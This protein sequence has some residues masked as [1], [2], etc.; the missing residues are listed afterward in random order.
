MFDHPEYHGRQP[1]PV[2]SKLSHAVRPKSVIL[3]RCGIGRLSEL[4]DIGICSNDLYT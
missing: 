2:S 4:C 3:P 1:S